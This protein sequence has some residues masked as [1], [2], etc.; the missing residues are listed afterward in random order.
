MVVMNLPNVVNSRADQG[1]LP[2]LAL[3]DT[4]ALVEVLVGDAL[5]LVVVR[6]LGGA[7]AG[8]PGSPA[9]APGVSDPPAGTLSI[10]RSE[11]GYR[12]N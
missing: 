2:D 5:A 11:P 7:A 1:R 12:H 6:W 3:G 10:P 9:T 4:L 8:M